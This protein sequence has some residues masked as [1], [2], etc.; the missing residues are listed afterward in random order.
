MMKT[1]LGANAIPVQIPGGEGDLF[2]GIIDIITMRARIFQEGS[3]G[4]T[5]DDMEIPHDMQ[6]LAQEYRTKM[7][8]A[9]SDEDDTLLE[10][11]LEGKEISAAEIKAVLRRAALKVSIVPVLCGSSFKNKGVQM[12]LDAVIDFLPSPVDVSN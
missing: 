1:R 3:S 5:W 10:K 11:Y 7:L 2:T 4:V 6:K 8:E 12:L 9:V